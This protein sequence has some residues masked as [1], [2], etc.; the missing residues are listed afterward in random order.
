M[1]LPRCGTLFTY[2]SA[3]VMRTFRSPLTG[4]ITFFALVIL[5][6]MCDCAAI[7]SELRLVYAL[8]PML[9]DVHEMRDRVDTVYT[10]R[11]A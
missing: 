3:D 11:D 8:H 6:Y 9:V 4:S 5:G 2:G 7:E 10:L 1:M